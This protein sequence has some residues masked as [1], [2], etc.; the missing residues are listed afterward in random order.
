M[1]KQFVRKRRS[2]IRWDRLAL[3]AAPL[4]VTTLVLILIFRGIQG[5]SKTGNAAGDGN[6]F[7]DSL[8]RIEDSRPLVEGM[9]AF[10]AR[11]G[12][13]PY[14]SLMSGVEPETLDSFAQNRYQA[15]F[16]GEGRLL[17]VYDEW[18]EGVYYLS[19]QAGGALT[20]DDL[21]RFLAAMERAYADP[22][23]G[24]YAAAFG[25]GFRQGAE[26]LSV[27]TDGSGTGL[28]TALGLTLLVLSVVLVLL[29]RRRVRAMAR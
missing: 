2:G 10:E 9:K 7:E 4:L 21:S 29:M 17:V 28:L 19:A 15:H 11:T 18:E 13:R 3:L 6:W 20:E 25:A 26:E 23:N 5:P 27:K 16:S 12:I 1:A 8:G 24:S 22:A 14:L